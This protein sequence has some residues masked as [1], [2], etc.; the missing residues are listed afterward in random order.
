MWV[1]YLEYI[2]YPVDNTYNPRTIAHQCFQTAKHS[3]IRT[4]KVQGKVSNVYPWCVSLWLTSLTLQMQRFDSSQVQ[5]ESFDWWCHYH[6]H[7]W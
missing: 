1:T 5:N 7:L 6:E 3:L 4:M 2:P